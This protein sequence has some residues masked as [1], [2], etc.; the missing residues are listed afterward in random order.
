MMWKVMVSA[1]LLALP[2]QAAPEISAEADQWLKTLVEKRLAQAVAVGV[3]DAQG[4]TTLRFYGQRDAASKAPVQANTVFEIGSVSKVFNAAL[5]ARRVQ[6]GFVK[7]DDP[8]LTHLPKP[9]T[10]PTRSGQAITLQHLVTHTS[11]LPRLPGNLK[12]KDMANPYADYTRDNLWAFLKTYSLPRDPGAKYEYSNLGSGLLSQALTH[13]AK[14]AYEPLLQREVLKPWGM[15]DTGIALRADQLA[16]LAKGFNGQHEVA[17]W[18]FPTLPGAGALR[19][20]LTDMVRFAGLQLGAISHP[21]QLLFEQMAQ[22]LA[23]AD[24]N[25]KI[26]M[27]WHL[28]SRKDKT[29]AWHNG[30]TGGYRSFVGVDRQGGRAM[31][32]L[33]STNTDLDALALHVLDPAFPAPALPKRASRLQQM[34]KTVL[35]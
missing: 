25:M 30:G 26:G 15:P 10:V 11:G 12:P 9:V 34:L 2:A 5:L 16:R 27:G 7:L 28:F 22:P 8:V 29:Y 14:M 21:D 20:T 3:I 19:S 13:Q 17:N 18:D 32:I 4:E 24:G 31:V 1:L 35:E 6:Q 23:H 33:A